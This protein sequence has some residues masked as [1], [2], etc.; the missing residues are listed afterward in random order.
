MTKIHVYEAYGMIDA[1]RKTV[2]Q[3]RQ[4]VN[5]VFDL[6]YAEIVDLANALGVAETV[7]RKVGVQQ[8]RSNVPS[9]SAKEHYKRNVAIPLLDAL[10]QQRDE[11]FSQDSRVVGFSN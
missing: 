11:Q 3:K 8:H 2:K 10:S 5:D 4:N 9:E 7:A 6:W 1:T